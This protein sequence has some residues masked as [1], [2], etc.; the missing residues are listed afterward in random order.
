MSYSVL[1]E[2]MLHVTCNVEECY[3]KNCRG[4]VWCHHGPL[5]YVQG[6]SDA[7]PSHMDLGKSN[8]KS[9]Y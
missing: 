2:R 8:N 4:P 3:K 1:Q 9:E 5:D 6:T 7:F